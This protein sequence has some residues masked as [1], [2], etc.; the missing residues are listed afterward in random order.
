MLYL[1]YQ[2]FQVWCDFN[3]ALIYGTGFFAL[4]FSAVNAEIQEQD[5][6]CSVD[7][8]MQSIK[9]ERQVDDTVKSH[10]KNKFKL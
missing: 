3:I 7:N 1:Q 9:W 4:L 10:D 6:E 2:T 8:I 5:H